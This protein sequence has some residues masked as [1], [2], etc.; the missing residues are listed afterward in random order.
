LAIQEGFVVEDLVIKQV[1]PMFDDDRGDEKERGTVYGKS[2]K[3]DL[4][5]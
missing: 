1:K 2:L 4:R 3:Y 5:K